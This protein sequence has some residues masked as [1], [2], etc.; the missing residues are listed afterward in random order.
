MPNKRSNKNTLHVYNRK[1]KFFKIFSSFSA[2]AKRTLKVS[3][4]S[5]T[6]S[7]AHPVG[8]T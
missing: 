3:K 7:S 5:I 6:E 2:Q 8:T 4:H 1:T